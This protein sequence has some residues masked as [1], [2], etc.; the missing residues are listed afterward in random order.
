MSDEDNASEHQRRDEGLVEQHVRRRL[1]PAEQAYRQSLTSLWIG[2]GA[3]S[4]AALSF[5]GAASRD[6][7]FSH[8]LLWPLT[9]FVLGLISMGVGTGLYLLKE[10]SVIHQM[11]RAASVWGF[12][13]GQAKSPSEKAGLALTDPRT[14]AAVLSAAFFVSGCFIG[15]VELWTA[16]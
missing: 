10:G 14:C 3:A 12:A 11:E 9:C 13:A 1:E 5:I 2:N 15:L 6:G 4:L 8:P 16:N 7:K